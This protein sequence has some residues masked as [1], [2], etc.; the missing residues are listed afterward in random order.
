MTLRAIR[1]AGFNKTAFPNLNNYYMV[2]EP[3]AAA[4]YTAR[5][6]KED[7]KQEFLKV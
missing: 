7:K 4:I 3:E 2:T 5:Y 1:E 6:L